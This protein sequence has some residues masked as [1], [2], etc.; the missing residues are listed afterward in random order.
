MAMT[1]A[2]V[3]SQTASFD[4]PKTKVRAHAARA[5]GKI[6][7]DGTLDEN[8]WLL[9]K[10]LSDFVMI[11]PRQGTTPNVKTAVRVLFDDHA[12]YIGAR[13]D[14][15]A[16]NSG[17]QQIDLRRDFELND[18]DYFGIA[19]D[20]LGDGRNAFGFFV[21]PYGAQ[22]DVQVVDDELFE[23]KWDTVWKS[24]VTRDAEGYTV[25][26]AIPWKSLRTVKGRTEFGFQVARQVRRFA[27]TDAWSPYPR[28]FSP[29]R[30][31]YAGILDGLEPTEPKLLDAQLRPYG[32]MRFDQQG[33]GPISVQPNAGGEVTW[34]PSASTVIDLTANTD[35]AETDVDRRVINLSRFSV[36]FPE[37]RQFFLE[38]AGVF[39][40][41][42]EDSLIDPFFSRTIGLDAT[43]APVPINAG[44]RIISRSTASS[45]GALVVNTASTATAGSSLFGVAR[46]THNVGDESRAG[47]MLVV[48]QD[49]AQGS[50]MPVTN[51]VPVAD[52]LA[53]FGP[54][55][56]IGMATGSLTQKER[57]STLGG[58][59]VVTA[60]VQ[61]N[62]GQLSAGVTALSQDYDAR[63][64][65]I[66]RGE[67]LVANSTWYFDLR[68]GWLP[69]FIRS[70]H[71]Y[72]EA[73]L[74]TSTRDGSF[75]SGSVYMEPLWVRTS[76][77]DRIWFSAKH[78]TEALSEPF[79]GVRG[80]AV[81]SGVYNFDEY[82]LVAY[83]EKSRIV[84]GGGS[85]TF[86]KFYRSDLFQIQVQAGFQPMPH[87]S[88]FF[89]YDFNRFEGPDVLFGT[90]ATTHLLLG[91]ARIALNPK[92]QL[93]GSYQRDTSGNRSI[94][95]ARLAWE[96]LP[97]S[98]LYVVYTDSR[99]AFAASDSVV[100]EQK[101]V[102]KL[103]YTWRL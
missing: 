55:T 53:R 59:G 31:P 85:M 60:K 44:A 101:L 81:P 6:A 72:G 51:V 16:G 83:S 19:L 67:S 39:S 17:I 78:S 11:E 10:P 58:A 8:D 2:V 30:M 34:Q 20:T 48:R 84:S 52:G 25:E 94:A 28:A 100:S 61:A 90:E 95:N 93:I 74:V 38:N 82:A 96:F 56:I 9:A 41:G 87:V 29:F 26:L 91:E 50:L 68:P 57:V 4:P 40:P 66:A 27:E 13:C 36:F 1:T 103:T 63:A 65:F 62:W 88:L 43:G 23:D 42:P 92:L 49:F 22:A 24:A 18:N 75:Q 54:L 32:I 86:G 46:Y 102:M 12:L 14:D 71:T 99:S 69:S 76:G 15:P 47:G 97:L 5:A 37:R 7:I 45:I 33:D 70:I 89:R 64:G 3:L 80:V 79:A 77:G 35:F 73:L 98:F 21:N